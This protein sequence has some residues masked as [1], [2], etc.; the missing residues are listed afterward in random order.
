MNVQLGG[1]PAATTFRTDKLYKKVSQN[2]ISCVDLYASAFTEM[3]R[4]HVYVYTFKKSIEQ[5]IQNSYRLK[6]CRPID[7]DTIVSCHIHYV[8]GRKGGG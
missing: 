4:S 6:K 1:G 5:H 3:T 2:N 7:F 8:F